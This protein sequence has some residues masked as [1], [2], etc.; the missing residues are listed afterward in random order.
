MTGGAVGVGCTALRSR[1]RHRGSAASLTA[2]VL[3]RISV[4]MSRHR[5]RRRA[6]CTCRSAPHS[7]EHTPCTFMA[8]VIDHCHGTTL[9]LNLTAPT[10][11]ELEYPFSE[12]RS[13]TSSPTESPPHRI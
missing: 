4:H 12:H 5:V 9:Y 10:C 13:R 6:C 3:L 2:A 8:H 7:L 11:R 1:A